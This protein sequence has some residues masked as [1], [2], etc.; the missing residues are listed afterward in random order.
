MKLS[1][2]IRS[3]LNPWIE[4]IKIQ[5]ENRC[6]I[7]NSQENLVVH[8]IYPFRK[9]LKEAIASLGY[10]EYKTVDKYTQNELNNIVNVVLG[11]HFRRNIGV[12]LN[13][14]IHVKFHELYGKCINT[15]GVEEYLDFKQNK[16]KTRTLKKQI[17]KRYKKTIDEKY[18]TINID[19]MKE[20]IDISLKNVEYIKKYI[21]KHINTKELNKV[22]DMMNYDFMK[23]NIISVNDK[24][25]Y[26]LFNFSYLY[27][28]KRPPR[29][30]HTI[31]RI[32][33]MANIFKIHKLQDV[34]NIGFI[35][36]N[37]DVYK[38]DDLVKFCKS[39]IFS[40]NIEDICSK[41][42]CIKDMINTINEHK[43]YDCYLDWGTFKIGLFKNE[44][45]ISL[46]DKE[47][48]KQLNN[49][50]KNIESDIA[51]K[52]NND[53]NKSKYS[54]MPHIVDYLTSIKKYDMHKI[55]L[56]VKLYLQEMLDCYGW[57]RIRL[58]KELKEKYKYEG[59]GYPFI[60]VNE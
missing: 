20:L 58:N 26:I 24:E 59:E 15:D 21:I 51:Y 18:K 35:D 3:F 5:Y 30:I 16:G 56:Y 11:I 53:I 1:L 13:Q 17:K 36:Y 46:C 23:N 2:Y 8:H 27:G 37:F 12:L 47:E 22:L 60:I 52:V 19:N 41:I 44:T 4:Y 57:K 48:Y 32:F 25:I 38:R 45:F 6:D 28:S 43:Y 49:L 39:Y 7:T 40:I 42:L 31:F 33:N 55:R 29:I 14:D 9:I 34:N 54:L 10:N 50:I